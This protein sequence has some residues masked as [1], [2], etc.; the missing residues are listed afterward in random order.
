MELLQVSY[1]PLAPSPRCKWL[2][3]SFST[4]SAAAAYQASAYGAFTPA[5][6][7]F[8]GLASME[9]VGLYLVFAFGVVRSVSVAMVVVII[10]A[11]MFG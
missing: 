3:I 8:A 6:G 2:T 1:S 4:G 10:V 7:I 11:K 9:M 5:G